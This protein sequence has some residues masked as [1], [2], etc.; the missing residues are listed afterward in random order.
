MITCFLTMIWS[1]CC[2]RKKNSQLINGYVKN[3]RVII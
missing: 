1:F 3:L 2:K